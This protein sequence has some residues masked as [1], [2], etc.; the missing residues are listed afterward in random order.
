MKVKYI[1]VST[2]EQNTGRQ[3][4]NASEFSKI[5]TDRISGSVPFNERREARKLL[6]DIDT[7]LVTEV[8]VNAI[9]RLGR[10]I[11]NILQ[12]VEYLNEKKINLFV[13]NIGMFSLI[14]GKINPSF[15]LI[16]SVLGNVGEL[17][18]TNLLERQKAGIE[19][20]KL[21]G[22]YKGRLYGTTMTDEEILT[23]YKSVAK[24]LRNGESLR[25]AAKIGGCSLGTAQKLKSILDRAA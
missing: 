13:E 21:Q 7:G 17:E 11:L 5:Y 8:H 4:T 18:R 16:V 23:K 19:L 2:E 25:R 10:S 15:K 12:V 22:K 9:D 3:E 1:R 24:E 20:A 14:G 6:A